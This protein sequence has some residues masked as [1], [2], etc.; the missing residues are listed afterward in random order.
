MI[1]PINIIVDILLIISLLLILNRAFSF[2][3]ILVDT[4]SH[5]KHKYIIDKKVPLSGG[6]FILISILYFNFKYSV[7]SEILF[8]TCPLIIIGY[9]SDKNILTSPLI[10][11]ILQIFFLVIAIINLKTFV[12]LDRLY[13]LDILL[14]QQFLNYL[15]V[16]ICLLVLINGSNFID[17]LNGLSSGYYLLIILSVMLIEPLDMIKI[18]SNIFAFKLLIP[19]IIFFIFNLLNKNFIG[20]NGIYFLSAYV[21]FNLIELSN[22]NFVSISPFYIV[23]LLWYPAFENLF[24]I[25]RRLYISRN[26]SNPDNLH[27]H[28]L[29]YDKIK[30]NYNFKYSNSIAAIVILL[31]CIPG[32]VLSTFYQ[33]QTI[34]LGY[35]V[36]C[37]ILLYTILY[38]Y[39]KNETKNS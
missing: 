30:K 17:G 6:A 31:L 26:V 9:L 27:L 23:S 35:I 22:N 20:D 21:G 28:A 34:I 4:S 12:I 19:L 37:N 5:S 33:N 25:I 24:S 3:S 1:I 15:F 18:E 14:N 13:Y 10:R 11:M 2:Q 38:L 8:Y 36:F 39:L 29:I 7:D 16:L 32:F